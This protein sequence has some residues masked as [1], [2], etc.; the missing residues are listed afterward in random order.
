MSV[1]SL[2]VSEDALKKQN[3]IQETI[4]ETL[5][6][7]RPLKVKLETQPDISSNKNEVKN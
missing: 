5:S 4:I 7:R 1:V 3:E 6:G 2:P